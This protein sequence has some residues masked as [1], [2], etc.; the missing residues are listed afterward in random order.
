[1]TFFIILII[2][3][4]LVLFANLLLDPAHIYWR[5]LGRTPE[6]V[7]RRRKLEKLVQLQKKGAVKTLFIGDSRSYNLDPESVGLP[8]PAF[9]FTSTTARDEDFLAC[10]KLVCK[11]QDKPPEFLLIG[12]TAPVFHPS[13]PLPLEASV[14]GDYTD[15]LVKIGAMP[16]GVSLKLKVLFS[17]EHYRRS[18]KRLQ[19]LFRKK[20]NRTSKFQMR[21]DGFASWTRKSSPRDLKKHV[22][23]FPV[24][25]LIISSFD[26]IRSKR[27]EWW[28]Q[29]LDKASK[30]D[31]K[32]IAYLLPGGHP[33]LLKRINDLDGDRIHK[34]V[35]EYVEK[36]VNEHNGLFID[37]YNPSDS[38]LTADDFRDGIHLQDDSQIKVAQIIADMIRRNIVNTSENSAQS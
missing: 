34:M 22:K 37:L 16:S 6:W 10:Y 35:T 38:G 21:D 36:S 25:G 7:I 2:L 5:D 28:E 11:G 14:A 24:T 12:C 33:D 8:S 15:E 27:K 20:T 1:L 31:T 13:A 9:N 29:L 17:F 3:A 4:T 18:F 26:S 30:N 32:I 19:W 23:Y